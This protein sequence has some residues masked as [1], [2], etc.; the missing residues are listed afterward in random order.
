[1]ESKG[2]ILSSAYLMGSHAVHKSFKQI[3]EGSLQLLIFVVHPDIMLGEW[4]P[5]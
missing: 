4:V 5:R 3:I 2:S 1:M